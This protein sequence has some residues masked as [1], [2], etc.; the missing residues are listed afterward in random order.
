MYN[1]CV[2]VLKKKKTCF[3][4][5]SVDNRIYSR[6][7]LLIGRFRKKS[8]Y[9]KQTK[10]NVKCGGCVC[11]ENIITSVVSFGGRESKNTENTL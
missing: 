8:Y 4:N 3:C 2:E 7:E 5:L 9:L 10:I 1:F 11:K 6:R